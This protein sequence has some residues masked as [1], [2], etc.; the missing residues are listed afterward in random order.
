MRGSQVGGNP[1]GWG[2]AYYQG[3][4]VTLLR[5]PVPAAKSPM[6][7]FLN[8]HAPRSDLIISHIRRATQGDRVLANTQPFQ[9]VLGGR[10]HVFAHNG[11]V[12]PFGLSSTSSWLFPKGD[13]DSELLFCH[14]LG[15]LE[16]LWSGG[17]TPAFEKRFDVIE[18]FAREILQLGASNF[19]YSDGVTL[20]AHGH[21]QTVPGDAVSDEPGLYFKR[22]QS[23]P[24]S[25]MVVPCTG[26]RTEGRCSHQAL[27]AS[28]PLD[29]DNWEALESG[30]IACFE[31]G[32]RIR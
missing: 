32:Q 7:Q 22:H 3:A 9:R 15:F 8:S 30:E 16:P 27:V 4:D 2:V 19:L 6:V 25:D 20:F 23:K 13:T 28:L 1:D 29:D 12:P 21:R 5:E 24:G 17:D 14:L 26:L 18:S 31:R 10:T 11:Y